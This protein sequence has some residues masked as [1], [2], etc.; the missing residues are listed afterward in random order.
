MEVRRKDEILAT[1]DEN[2]EL[3]KL[4]FMPQ[5]FQYCGQ[6]FQVHKRAGKTCSEISGGKGVTYIPRRLRDTVHL[7]HRCDG[8]G[9]G[10]CQVGCLIFWKEA[11]LKPVIAN[12]PGG[13]PSDETFSAR[14]SAHQSS[15]RCTE[16]R[17]Y[18]AATR[19]GQEGDVR[20]S[21][22]A[23]ALLDAT[24]P[25][26]WWDARQYV[27]AYRSGNNSL[28]TVLKSVVYLLYYYG[29]FARF[30]RLGVPSRWLYD[31]FQMLWGGLPF[32][33]KSGKIAAGKTTPRLDLNL[34]PGEW[35][36]VKS[37]EQILETVDASAFNRGLSFDAELVPYCGNEY[38]VRN[39]VER[40]IDE[41]TGKMMKMKTP[42]VILE[43]VYC[44]SLYSG[45]RALCP[46]GV[47][48]WW[49][50]IW[51]ERVCENQVEVKEPPERTCHPHELIES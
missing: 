20:Y 28:G 5:L 3:D 42:A 31:R 40:F 43:N 45:K 17:V 2:G 21:C 27:E 16:E 24:T 39:R 8:L 37:Y 35:V 34:K 51:L 18:E 26:K 44:Q 13:H 49:R 41:K 23:T 9:Y 14:A 50:E 30:P 19:R 12:A 11:W 48:L 36:R 15:S 47:F 10:G 33:R 6:R 38:R 22:Q 7:Q 46:R 4:P 1:L 25:L 32:P 29:T